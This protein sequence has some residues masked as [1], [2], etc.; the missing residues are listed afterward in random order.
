MMRAEIIAAMDHVD[1][2]EAQG[3]L[4]AACLFLFQARDDGNGLSHKRPKA[5]FERGS[6]EGNRSKKAAQCGQ[7][8]VQPAPPFV[9]PK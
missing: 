1:A 9:Q 8:N 3:L 4:S 5:Y 6:G 2:V 7:V